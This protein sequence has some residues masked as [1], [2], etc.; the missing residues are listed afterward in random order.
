[1]LRACKYCG[2]VHDNKL[3]CPKKPKRKRVAKAETRASAIRNTNAWH[4]ARDRTKSRDNYLCRLC[5]ENYDYT[6]RRLNYENLEVHHIVP[7]VEEGKAFS[8]DNLIT[9]CHFHHSYVENK[10]EVRNYLLELAE[11]EVG[12]IGKAE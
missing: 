10:P 8:L 4:V 3:I 5:L 2:R 12:E 11:K 7:L 6:I 1:M 9:L